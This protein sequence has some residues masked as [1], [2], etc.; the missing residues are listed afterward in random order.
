MSSISGNVF[1]LTNIYG[2]CSAP[3]KTDFINWLYNFDASTY[4]D[5][6]LVGDFNLIRYPE[7]INRPGGNVNDMMAFSNL[8]LHLDLIEIPFKGRS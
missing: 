5:W 2:P 4:D 8:I 7:N 3:G 1:H 6:I